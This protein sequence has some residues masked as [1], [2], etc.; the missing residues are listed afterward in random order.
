[1][2]QTNVRAFEYAADHAGAKSGTILESEVTGGGF[3]GSVSGKTGGSGERVGVG[4]GVK[5]YVEIGIVWDSV[6]VEIWDEWVAEVLWLDGDV[7]DVRTVLEGV[8]EVVLEGGEPRA[9]GAK[10]RRNESLQKFRA[11]S[12]WGM[13]GKI[14]FKASI[15]RRVFKRSGH[16]TPK[17]RERA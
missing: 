17:S 4:K 1:M 16:A 13:M 2:A 5:G 3:N 12:G 11:I 6:W 14:W 15:H 9:Y 7:G 10:R 8:D